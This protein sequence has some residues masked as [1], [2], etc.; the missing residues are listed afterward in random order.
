MLFLSRISLLLACMAVFGCSDMAGRQQVTLSTQYGDIVVEVYADKAPNSAGDF[1]R[2]VEKGL[3]VGA[4][5]YRVVRP[6]NDNG[7]P[8][9]SVIQGGVLEGG[10]ALGPVAHEP[11]L[12]TGLQHVDGALSLA[13]GDVGTGSASAFFICIGPQPSL[14]QG[15]MR[16]PDGAGFAVFGQVISGMEVVRQIHQLPGD[17]ATQDAYVAGQILS[18]P[19]L[20][21]ASLTP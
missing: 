11:T 13:R 10:A 17:A 7:S 16:N 6:G 3:F 2:Y 15:G 20:F 21:E 5:F 4:G 8:V 1:M 9:I 19:V 12:Q 18:K 14:D